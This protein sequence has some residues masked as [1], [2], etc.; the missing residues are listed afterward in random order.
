MSREHVRAV[1]VQL[2]CRLGRRD[3]PYDALSDADLARAAGL[4]RRQAAVARMVAWRLTNREIGERLGLSQSTVR[5][6]IEVVFMRFDLHGRRQ[7]E[8]VLYERIVSAEERRP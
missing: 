3:A 1:G 5:R 4:S 2:H 7:V 6:H 8:A